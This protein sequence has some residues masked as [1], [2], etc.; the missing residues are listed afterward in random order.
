[1]ECNLSV[2][3]GGVF[4]T[5]R[6][7]LAPLLKSISLFVFMGY[8]L[9]SVQNPSFRVFFPPPPL[10]IDILLFLFGGERE[11]ESLSREENNSVRESRE[12]REELAKS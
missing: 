11:R 12:S 4:C 3:G 9:K 2:N 7:F 10:T 8:F 6:E 1:M 5:F